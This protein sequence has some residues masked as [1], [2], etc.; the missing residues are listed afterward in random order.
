LPGQ[1]RQPPTASKASRISGILSFPFPHHLPAPY[2]SHP[3]RL[4]IVKQYV[5][6]PITVL[7]GHQITRRGRS[8]REHS[9]PCIVGKEWNPFMLHNALEG[10]SRQLTQLDFPYYKTEINESRKK[11]GK[12]ED[13]VELCFVTHSDQQAEDAR[14][15]ANPS[16]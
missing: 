8:S 3:P 6:N 12:K 2:T 7:C 14:L 4:L 13:S 10:E 16:P 11:R 9:C 1:M 5:P 15:S